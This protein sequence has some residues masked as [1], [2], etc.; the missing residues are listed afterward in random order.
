VRT[1][2]TSHGGDD[3][4]APD[5]WARWFA[6]DQAGADARDSAFVAQKQVQVEED[7]DILFA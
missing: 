7:G 1:R 5:Q 6:K 2:I 3:Q 4:D